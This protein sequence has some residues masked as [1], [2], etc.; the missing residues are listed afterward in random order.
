MISEQLTNW[1][2]ESDLLISDC[3]SRHL[4]VGEITEMAIELVILASALGRIN[5][6]YRKYSSLLV[7]FTPLCMHEKKKKVPMVGIQVSPSPSHWRWSS[8][9]LKSLPG[10]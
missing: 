1:K 10:P 2:G 9:I 8:P 5:I 3:V 7:V 4:E 6:P